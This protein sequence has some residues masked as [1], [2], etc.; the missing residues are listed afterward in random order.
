[1]SYCKLY[2]DTGTDQA[3]LESEFAQ[4][5]GERVKLPGVEYT[6][7][8]ND[9]YKGADPVSLRDPIA[10]SRYYV[11]I[12]SDPSIV[13]ADDDFCAEIAALVIWLRQRCD[14]VVASCDFENYITEATGW[15]WTPERPLPPTLLI[16]RAQ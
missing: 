15:N 3:E 7:F 5:F 10:R 4:G 6:V 2:I 8:P 12:D 13:F 9:L 16:E 11:E 14:Y 1:M